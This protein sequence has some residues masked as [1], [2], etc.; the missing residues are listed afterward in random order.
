[1]ILKVEDVKKRNLRSSHISAN[2]DA[3]DQ[4]MND[5]TTLD[6]DAQD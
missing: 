2:S 6:S 5:N 1:M 3:Q 4:S